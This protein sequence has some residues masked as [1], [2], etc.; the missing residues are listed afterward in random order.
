[1]SKKAFGTIKPI[2]AFVLI[3]ALLGSSALAVDTPTT[4]ISNIRGTIESFKAYKAD[5]RVSDGYLETL[6]SQ[7]FELEKAVKATGNSASED[8]FKVLDEAESA[9]NSRYKTDASVKALTAVSTVR[10]S[11]SRQDADVQQA[12][13]PNEVVT[14]FTDMAESHWAYKAVM[15]C[16]NRGAINGTTP[17]VNGVGTF[18]PNGTV[19][20]GEFLTVFARLVAKDQIPESV[21]GT[22]WATPYY[23]ASITAGII[24]PSEYTHED[25]GN[26]LSR[27]EMAHIMVNVAI[28][29][30]ETLSSKQNVQNAIP[31]YNKVKTLYRNDVLKCYSNGLITGKDGGV[32]DPNGTMTRAEMAMVIARLMNYVDRAPVNINNEGARSHGGYV[33]AAEGITKGMLES[34]YSRE[35]ELQALGACRTGEDAKGVYVTFTAPTLPAELQNDFTVYFIAM[36]KE[37]DG[38]DDRGNPIWVNF[39]NQINVDLKSGE[40]KTV[41]FEGW[42]GK[43]TS[44]QIDRMSITVEV[45]NAND[46]AMFNRTIYS[47]NP[48]TANAQWYDGRYDL[49]DFDSSAVWQGIGK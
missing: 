21:P 15:E 26:P 49:V 47:N 43:V 20:L 27:Q 8:V 3:M 42:E 28:I 25:L 5:R 19:T 44:N 39:A 2:C 46:E 17:A 4:A 36:V 13:A 41:Y 29:N 35:F 45:I 23:E 10:G 11:L 40:S 14:S 33:I 30:G 48:T 6:A 22:H 38:T 9:I 34:K 7:L 16:V 18:N 24:T 32:F 31:D 12:Q 1:M 37:Q